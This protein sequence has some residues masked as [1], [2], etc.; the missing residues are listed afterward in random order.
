MVSRKFRHSISLFV[1]IL[2]ML[3]CN[4][5][6]NAQRPVDIEP[7][8]ATLGLASATASIIIPTAILD[9]STPT[10]TATMTVSATASVVTITADGGNL[11]VRRGPD[12]GYNPVSGLLK[13]ETA[14]VI[15]RNDTGDWLKLSS[16]PKLPGKTGW[17]NAKTKYSLV[18]GD[19]MSLPVETVSPPQ[20][21]YILKCTSH[22]MDMYPIGI[23]VPPKNEKPNNK[24]D[25][26]P[27]E[28]EVFDSAVAGSPSVASITVLEG[29][30]AR[31]K[32]DGNGIN[33]P[34]P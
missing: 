13:G 28:Y 3:A 4:I 10:E 2:A 15:A 20:P 22:S 19:V 5:P 11:N 6:I 21:A 29:Q 32:T 30:T 34:C 25:I 17:V 8:P 23:S 12:V 33:F 14:T 16:I 31:I 26:A 9:T 27:G 24:V 18:T 1:L 7:I